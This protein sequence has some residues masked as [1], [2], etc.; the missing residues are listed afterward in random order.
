[1]ISNT[2]RLGTKPN[3]NILLL[4]FLLKMPNFIFGDIVNNTDLPIKP[5]NPMFSYTLLV[6]VF[7]F[8]L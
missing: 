8:I 7:L 6:T 5:K 3:I 2:F 1:M 4:S